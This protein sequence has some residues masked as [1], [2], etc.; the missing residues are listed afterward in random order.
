MQAVATTSPAIWTSAIV[1]IFVFGAHIMGKSPT[2]AIMA[3]CFIV[4]ITFDAFFIRA[5]IEPLFLAILPTASYWPRELPEPT[6]D[7]EHLRATWTEWEEEDETSEHSAMECEDEGNGAS[8]VGD[9]NPGYD[10]DKSDEEK[11]EAR[12]FSLYSTFH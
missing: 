10:S 4:S 12:E 1:M 5:I 2:M 3:T 8:S 7:M 11:G 6:R 9:S